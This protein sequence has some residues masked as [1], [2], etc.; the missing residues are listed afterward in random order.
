MVISDYSDDMDPEEQIGSRSPTSSAVAAIEEYASAHLPRLVEEALET[1]VAQQT[2]PME[3]G[4][5]RALPDIVR[6]CHSRLTQN[7]LQHR[8]SCQDMAGISVETLPSFYVPPLDLTNENPFINLDNVHSHEQETVNPPS[9]SG[10]ASG[11]QSHT[12]NRR[13]PPT[14]ATMPPDLDSFFNSAY[15]FSDSELAALDLDCLNVPV[16]GEKADF[17]SSQELYDESLQ[18]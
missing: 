5:R 7:F 18:P 17:N 15:G 11:T 10:Y 1:A 8:S 6:E 14:E 12:W 9:D 16:A 4:L 3:E 2:Q 13:E